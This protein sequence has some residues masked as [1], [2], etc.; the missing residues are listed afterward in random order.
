MYALELWSRFAINSNLIK[1]SHQPVAIS[2]FLKAN[3]ISN[4]EASRAAPCL[5]LKWF[6]LED[7]LSR[8]LDREVELVTDGALSPY[9][10][11][12]AERD[13]VLLY[14]ER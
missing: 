11:P 8:I 5:G 10:K 13:M 9:V 14:E 2:L 4:A 12:Y 3:Y 7:E 6:G 1:I